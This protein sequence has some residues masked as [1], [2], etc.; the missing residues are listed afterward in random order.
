MLL[1]FKT[2]LFDNDPLI[3]LPRP[4]KTTVPR[5]VLGGEKEVFGDCL[6]HFVLQTISKPPF[7]PFPETGPGGIAKCDIVK[8]LTG[9]KLRRK[10]PP[11]ISASMVDV[12]LIWVLRTQINN[13]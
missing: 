1:I 6:Q 12:L 2:R 11:D 13:T 9:E 5:P 4:S 10:Y 7:P 8:P 3:N